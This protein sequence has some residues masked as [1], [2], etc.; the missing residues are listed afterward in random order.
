MPHMPGHAAASAQQPPI[1]HH[2]AANSG[3]D[4][5]VDQMA[6]ALA[7]AVLPFAVSG[8]NAIVFHHHRPSQ[9]A[10]ARRGA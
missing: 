8:G 10:L 3:A 6:Q 7:R 9:F 4:G 1:H 2:A 5:D